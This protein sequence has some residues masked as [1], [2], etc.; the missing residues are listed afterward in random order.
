VNCSL[1]QQGGAAR[2]WNREAT[3]AEEFAQPVEG[4]VHP[5]ASGVFGHTQGG[6]DFAQ[7]P[8]FKETQHERQPFGFTQAQQT[9]VQQRDKFFQRRGAV[10]PELGDFG[11]GHL[12]A[13]AAELGADAGLGLQDGRAMK[14]AGDGFVAGE[15][16]RL[17][18]QGDEG[19]LGNLLRETGVADL[20]ERRGED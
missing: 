19:V 14:P 9:L 1:A 5:L 18:G 17:A 3:C 10:T 15:M 2:G 4:A 20:P 8:P 11:G 12:A 13:L 6:A 7:A 16:R